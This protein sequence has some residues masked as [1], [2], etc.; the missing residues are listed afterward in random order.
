MSYPRA[1]G[2]AELSL[3]KAARRRPIPGILRYLGVVI[4]E[5]MRIGQRPVLP[6]H[7]TRG[8]TVR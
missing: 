3:A 5:A 2:P 1:V 4:H 6:R 8:D 7:Q